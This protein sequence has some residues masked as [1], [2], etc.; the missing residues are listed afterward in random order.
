MSITGY[1]FKKYQSKD[2][3]KQKAEQIMILLNQIVADFIMAT[4]ER[5]E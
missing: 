4:N 5:G 2:S 1:Y 3:A